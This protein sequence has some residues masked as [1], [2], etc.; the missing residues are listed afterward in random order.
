V[1]GEASAIV[2]EGVGTRPEIDVA[3]GV[4]GCRV[5]AVAVACSGTN[6]ARRGGDNVWQARLDNSRKTKVKRI[7]RR[8]II[9]IIMSR[10]AYQPYT[11]QFL[12]LNA[13]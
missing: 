2:A 6:A 11:Q 1:P 3:D 13:S 10:K 9:A 5:S 4:A 12:I 8:F 7:T